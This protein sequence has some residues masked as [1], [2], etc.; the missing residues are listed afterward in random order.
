LVS[1]RYSSASTFQF[2]LESLL[3]PHKERLCGS[4]L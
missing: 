3:T 2:G 4:L 1:F